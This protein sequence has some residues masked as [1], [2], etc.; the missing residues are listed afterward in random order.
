[1]NNGAGGVGLAARL[2]WG[3]AAIAGAICGLMLIFMLIEDLDSY[4]GGSRRLGAALAVSR[5]PVARDGLAPGALHLPPAWLNSQDRSIASAPLAALLAA[6]LGVDVSLTSNGSSASL[7]LA[8]DEDLALRHL[9]LSSRTHLFSLDGGSSIGLFTIQSQLVAS[10]R[11]AS[12]AT[13]VLLWSRPSSAVVRR[14]GQFDPQKPRILVDDWTVRFEESFPGS[15]ERFTVD[16]SDRR[17]LIV[18][19]DADD[20][21]RDLTLLSFDEQW[22]K[23]SVSTRKSYKSGAVLA[24]AVTSSDQI[25]YAL[26][27]DSRQFVS[28]AIGDSARAPLPALGP[29]VTPRSEVVRTAGIVS[30]YGDRLRQFYTVKSY[31]LDASMSKWTLSRLLSTKEF[32]AAETAISLPDIQAVSNF[33]IASSPNT[34]CITSTPFVMTIDSSLAAKP[35]KI[36]NLDP[37]LQFTHVALDDD[38]DLIALADSF[39]SLVFLA[40]ATDRY[41]PVHWEVQMEFSVPAELSHLRIM[42]IALLKRGSIL[43]VILEG[44]VLVSFDLDRQRAEDLTAVLDIHWEIVLGVISLVL[45]AFLSRLGGN[46]GAAATGNN[47]ITRQRAVP[48]APPAPPLPVVSQSSINQ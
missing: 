36:I 48:E 47:N 43:V 14:R 5:V 32:A 22:R 15:L 13:T 40:R 24:V 38:G 27:G 7:P 41:A 10:S 46:A 33:V 17:L 4:D 26:D 8:T 42:S 37:R 39:N 34:A 12:V 16:Q 28:I 11:D 31:E 6:R 18:L 19:R 3:F 20:A 29:A 2:R 9:N 1:M 25:V 44:G 23:Q 21:T 30:F 45:Y 35:I